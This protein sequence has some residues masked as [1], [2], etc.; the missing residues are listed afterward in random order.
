MAGRHAGGEEAGELQADRMPRVWRAD[1]AV[2]TTVS[3][4]AFAIAR[5]FNSLDSAEGIHMTSKCVSRG[6][7]DRVHHHRKLI[8]VAAIGVYTAFGDIVRGQTS[9]AWRSR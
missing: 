7:H 4:R 2:K 9:G 8:A 1:F 5:A 3:R 6:Q